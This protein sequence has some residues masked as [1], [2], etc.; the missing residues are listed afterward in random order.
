MY[1]QIKHTETGMRVTRQHIP[2]YISSPF[3]GTSYT[4]D[5]FRTYGSYKVEDPEHWLFEGTNVNEGDSIGAYSANQPRVGSLGEGGVGASGFETDKVNR[6]SEQYSEGFQRLAVGTNIQGPAHMVFKETSSGGWI[7][8][9]ASIAFT[10]AL[11]HDPA[12]DKLMLNLLVAD[13]E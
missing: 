2:S 3:L 12:V 13:S 8:H 1:R 6:Y 4:G 5:G 10:G 9:A 7:F 11:F